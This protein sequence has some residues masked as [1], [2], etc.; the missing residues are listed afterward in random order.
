MKIDPNIHPHFG[1]VSGEV[2]EGL[3]VNCS[4]WFEKGFDRFLDYYYVGCLEQEL[5]TTLED[6]SFYIDFSQVC[7][8]A[9]KEINEDLSHKAFKGDIKEFWQGYFYAQETAQKIFYLTYTPD[10][11]AA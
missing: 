3:P 7:T 10:T 4:R 2:R 8:Y 1:Y 5:Q 9:F 11:V 6:G